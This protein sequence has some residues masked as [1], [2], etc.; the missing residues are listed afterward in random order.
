[1][2]RTSILK[3]EIL[4]YLTEEWDDSLRVHEN[5]L[6]LTTRALQLKLEER[7]ILITWPTLNIRLHVLLENETV[8]MLKTS[9]G[10]CWKPAEDTL[11]I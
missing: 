11:R 7:G 9:A 8:E 3:E 6:W 2:K 4:H 1:M 10:K 5:G